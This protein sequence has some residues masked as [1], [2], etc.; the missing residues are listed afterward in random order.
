MFNT[1][2]DFIHLVFHPESD[3][4]RSA[5][6]AAGGKASVTDSATL[7]HRDNDETTAL[8]MRV[9]QNDGVTPDWLGIR[10]VGVCPQSVTGQS[11]V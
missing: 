11:I 10:L 8:S 2:K 5:F 6:V 4:A 3:I 1:K 7:R 9:F